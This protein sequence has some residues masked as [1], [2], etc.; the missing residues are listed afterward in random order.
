ML[1]NSKPDDYVLATNTGY[2][3]RDFLN[4][5]FDTVNLDWE[6]FVKF[7]QRY[8][9]PTEVDALIGDYSKASGALNWQPKT[10]SPDIAII[11][12]QHHLSS[13]KIR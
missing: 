9:R 6:K 11:M 4:F 5:A 1:Q 7:D 10:L 13:P 8:E 3:V 12:V 2:S